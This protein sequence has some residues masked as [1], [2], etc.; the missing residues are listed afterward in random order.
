M[1]HRWQLRPARSD[2]RRPVDIPPPARERQGRPVVALRSSTG[3][4]KGL[5]FG[6]VS[7]RSGRSLGRSAIG[8]GLATVSGTT[9]AGERIELLRGH[10]AGPP[11]RPAGG[12]PPPPAIRLP[13]PDQHPENSRPSFA[14]AT[15][16][17]PRPTSLSTQRPPSALRAWDHLERSLGLRPVRRDHRRPVDVPP[18]ARERQGRPVVPGPIGRILAAVGAGLWAP[19]DR[20]AGCRRALISGRSAREADVVCD[21]GR[22]LT[23][24]SG[25]TAGARR[26]ELLRGHAAGPP[27]D[28]RAACRVEADGTAR[29]RAGRC[30][31]AR[32]PRALRALDPLRPMHRRDRACARRPRRRGRGAGQPDAAPGRASRSRARTPTRYRSSRRWPRSAIRPRRSTAAAGEPEAQPSSA[33]LRAVAVAGFGAMNVMLLSVAVW[34]GADGATRKTFHLVSALIAVPVVAYSGQ[35]FFAR[36]SARCADG[37]LNMDVPII[38]RGPADAGAQPVRDRARRRAGVLR[39]GGDAPL[40][41]PRRPLPRPAD[42]RPGAQRGRR[43]ASGSAR[44]E[45]LVVGGDGSAGVPAARRDRARHGAAHRAGRAGAG[46]RAGRARH[47]RPRPLAG[48][49]ARRCRW[50]SAAATSS[51]PAR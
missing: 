33:L 51:R 27:R 30:G 45:R 48:D 2:Y 40:L 42:A 18:P 17:P 36:R 14:T 46:R 35:P 4:P 47:V 34:S 7:A 19:C 20:P 41:P 9:A 39:C 44:R 43:A 15:V 16:L 24:G 5:D 22:G 3:M 37:R 21:W 29:R 13:L 11:R 50:R 1:M 32:A 23:T 26:I 31:R 49:R 12:P 38:A 8:R 6:Q 25:T 28:R 10:V